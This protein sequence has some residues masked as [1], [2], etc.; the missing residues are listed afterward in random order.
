MFLLLLF[1]RYFTPKVI[2][3]GFWVLVSLKLMR[4]ILPLVCQILRSLPATHESLLPRFKTLVNK[5]ENILI[6]LDQDWALSA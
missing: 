6:E 3:S 4:P 2:G 1:Y 5:N